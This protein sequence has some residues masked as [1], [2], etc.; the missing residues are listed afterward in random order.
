MHHLQLICCELPWVSLRDTRVG[1]PV[2]EYPS[3]KEESPRTWCPAQLSAS[4][5]EETKNSVWQVCCRIFGDQA[6]RSTTGRP[7]DLLDRSAQPRIVVVRVV[8]DH[9]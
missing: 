7:R 3:L 6:T 8:H 4:C 9:D 1:L 5:T 2:E